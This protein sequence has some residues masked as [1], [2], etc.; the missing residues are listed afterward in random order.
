MTLQVFDSEVAQ[1]RGA[2]LRSIRVIRLIRNSNYY[3]LDLQLTKSVV[4]PR[5]NC[6]Y[7]LHLY[8]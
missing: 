3:H 8:I 1:T 2:L 7:P 5:L 6:I 4:A